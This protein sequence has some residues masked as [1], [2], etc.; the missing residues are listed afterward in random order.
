M[1]GINI[2]DPSNPILTHQFDTPDKAKGIYVSGEYAFVGD[3]ETLEI[4]QVFQSEFDANNNIGQSNAVDASGETPLSEGHTVI[5]II[6][7]S[8]LLY[9]AQVIFGQVLLVEKQTRKL[10]ARA[11][12]TLWRLWGRMGQ[13]L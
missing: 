1:V 12:A 3:D 8:M 13:K 4:I 6:A 9:G 2:S 10:G 5:P 11:R 7:A